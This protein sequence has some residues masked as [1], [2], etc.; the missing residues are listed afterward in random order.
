M[1]VPTCQ[2]PV[3]LTPYMISTNRISKWDEESRS[4]LIHCHFNSC[5]VLLYSMSG[6]M[7]GCLPQ[8]HWHSV[9]TPVC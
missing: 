2:I 1:Y 8:F 3:Q 9:Q 7:F 4:V 5:E 6:D